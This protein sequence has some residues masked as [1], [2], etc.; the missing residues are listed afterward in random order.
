MGIKELKRKKKDL[1]GVVV[2]LSHFLS[3][4]RNNVVSI[5]PLP[6]LLLFFAFDE[7]DCDG[8]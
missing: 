6:Y 1:K 3:L 8:Y 4:L 7:R 5:Y 2:L